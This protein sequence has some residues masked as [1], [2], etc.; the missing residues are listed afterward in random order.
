[1]HVMLQQPRRK[2][3]TIETAVY[4]KNH[5]VVV[6]MLAQS[7]RTERVKRKCNTN[8]VFFSGKL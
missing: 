6:K 7:K 1:M 2:T 4:I 3:G 5:R 8:R